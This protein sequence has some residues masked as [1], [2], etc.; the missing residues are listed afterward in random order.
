M[1]DTIR[2]EPRLKRVPYLKPKKAINRAENLLNMSR[3]TGIVLPSGFM[4][5]IVYNDYHIDLLP[6]R[7]FPEK[8][9]T[10]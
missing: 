1:Q 8:A 7:N 4:G 10:R 5:M 3:C 6:P 9:I 2:G